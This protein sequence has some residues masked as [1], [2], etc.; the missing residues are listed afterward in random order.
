MTGNKKFLVLTLIMG[1]FVIITVQ[2]WRLPSEFE[3]TFRLREDEANSSI[4]NRALKVILFYTTMFGRP[5]W[6][7]FDAEQNVSCD[8]LTCKFTHNRDELQRSDAVIFHGTDLPSKTVIKEVEKKKPFKQRW[9]YF[10]MESPHNAGRNPALFNCMFNWTMTYRI[11]NNYSP[12]WRWLVVDIYRAAKRRGKYP[13][14][15]T[16]TEVNSCFSIY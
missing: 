6:P 16:D 4:T 14:L 9:I 15:T 3:R 12:K 10:L 5:K 8:Q 11:V 1:A 7:G 2:R 13:P